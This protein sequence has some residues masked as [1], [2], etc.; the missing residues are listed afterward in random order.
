MI[1]SYYS[2]PS[3]RPLSIC[4]I[5]PSVEIKLSIF[6]LGFSAFHLHLSVPWMVHYMDLNWFPKCA[7]K[8]KRERLYCALL[9]FW[10]LFFSFSLFKIF[11]PRLQSCKIV[12][13]TYEIIAFCFWDEK[14]GSFENSWINSGMHLP[15]ICL[16]SAAE[17]SLD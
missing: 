15:W 1:Y 5:C 12:R 17:T 16:W 10:K 14:D 4:L 2:W 9:I 3:F 8:Y 11:W 7:S 13:K 6:S